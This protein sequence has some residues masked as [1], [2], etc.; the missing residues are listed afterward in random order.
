MPMRSME[1]G[2]ELIRGLH[3]VRP[4]HHGTV[5]TVGGFDGVHRGHRAL[6]DQLK[7]RAAELRLP[8]TVI[9]F[10]PSPREF[11]MGDAA[12]ARLQ[13]F[14]EKYAA[15]AD[16]GIDRFLCLRFDQ[17]ISSMSAQQFVADVLQRTLQVRWVVVGHDFQFGRGREGNVDNLRE[18]AAQAGMGLD[19]FEPHLV[20]GERISSTLV[21][22]ALAA[23]DMSRAAHLLGRPYRISGR[24]IRGEQLGRRL[25]FPTANIRL[26][27]RVLPLTG[28]F[29]VRVDGPGLRQAPAVASLGTRPV[30]QG[31]V[32][33]LEV[34][35]FDFSGNLYH[36]HLDV[37]F[38]ERLRDERWF[39]DLDALVEQMKVDA[40][41]ARRIL[42]RRRPSP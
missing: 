8:S 15:L 19:V 21:R 35:V 29:A 36:S 4:E 14:R 1:I 7:L 3:N 9:S 23:G 12:P 42:S 5:T 34:N 25:G 22:E 27:R 6:F 18:L 11:F 17:K 26:Q 24:V 28:I 39:P 20:A 38:V 2:M 16:C 41:Q 10:E 31:T 40:D 37:D 32:P 30:V 33:L 13:R